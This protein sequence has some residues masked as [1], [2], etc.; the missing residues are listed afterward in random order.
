MYQLVARIVAQCYESLVVRGFILSHV[1]YEGLKSGEKLDKS[2]IDRSYDFSRLFRCSSVSRSDS[3]HF[4]LNY[5]PARWYFMKRDAYIASIISGRCIL[6]IVRSC[7]FPCNAVCSLKDV[8]A[9]RYIY[10]YT[11]VGVRINHER[12]S[13]RLRFPLVKNSAHRNNFDEL[14][15]TFDYVPGVPELRR[16][17]LL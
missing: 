16:E 13:S 2:K 1:N 15:F 4:S 11:F 10:I 3:T 6:L 14:R 17:T 5:E 9:Y 12:G 7:V 8:H